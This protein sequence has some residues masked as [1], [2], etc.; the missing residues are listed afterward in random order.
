MSAKWDFKKG[1]R[2][3][4]P[5]KGARFAEIHEICRKAAKI[6]ANGANDGAG[7]PPLH[8]D[9][10]KNSYAMQLDMHGVIV[11]DTGSKKTRLIMAPT[12]I[13]LCHAGESMVI[14]D[15]KGELLKMTKPLMDKLGYTV[16][17]VNL[18]RPETGS[19]WNPLGIAYDDYQEGKVSKSDEVLRDLAEVLYKTQKPGANDPFWRNSAVSY[20]VGLAQ[21]LRGECS[22]EEFHLEGLDYLNTTGKM[23]FAS[24]SY[25]KEYFS[26]FENKNAE[27]NLEDTLST[28][29]D[30]RAGIVSSY[31]EPMPIF[32][33]QENICDMMCRSDF[34]VLD[35][36]RK[37]TAIFLVVP[38]EKTTYNFITVTFIMQCYQRLIEAAHLIFDG[39]LP[40]RVNIILDEFGN[41]PAIKDVGP[42][43]S[44]SRSRNIRF[45]IAIQSTAQ[46]R[47]AY[48]ETAE[49]VMTNCGVWY[50]LKTKD[51]NLLNELSTRCGTV[52][53]EYDGRERPL[54][55]VSQLQRLNKDDGEVLILQQ[56]EY[57]FITRLP[58]VSEYGVEMGVS[59]KEM[60]KREKVERKLYD[61]RPLVKEA[62]K[63]KLMKDIPATT[64]DHRF[65]NLFE[66]DEE[67]PLEE[68][69]KDVERELDM[70]QKKAEARARALIEKDLRRKAEAK[71]KDEKAKRDAEADEEA[72]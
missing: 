21:L 5:R 41:L 10:D 44:A 64:A 67:A 35:L 31:K 4:V 59:L 48:G 57:P 20:F 14:N 6:K 43:L 15:S 8:V 55:S 54:L 1:L 45:F 69:L 2:A 32:A 33:A 16:Y 71:K 72:S 68:K 37:K 63:A 11:G 62:K 39:T 27:T 9:E 13:N 56:G 26:V 7:G 29:N 36:A 49:T 28:A 50:Y 22:K 70:A 58:D 25:L 51:M 40:R 30:T 23:R 47:I 34:D 3:H 46:L 42:M 19:R 53:G 17:I 38:D 65:I 66:D 52:I 24:S 60:Q 61:I 18:R 12:I